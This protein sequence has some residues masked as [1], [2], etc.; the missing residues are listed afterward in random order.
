MVLTQVGV[1]LGKNEIIP[2]PN[3]LYQ[4][5]FPES[6]DLNLKSKSRNLIE[7]NTGLVIC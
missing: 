5:L 6:L 3:T 7:N 1:Y 2:L 4:T